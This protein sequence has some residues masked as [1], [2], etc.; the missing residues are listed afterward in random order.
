M[1]KFYQ[2]RQGIGEEAVEIFRKLP[3]KRKWELCEIEHIRWCRYHFMNNWDY[4]PERNNSQRR[5]NLLVPFDKLDKKNQEKDM[6]A[7]LVLE[8]I[9]K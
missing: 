4:A 1:Q 9:M 8:E 5:H 7:Y 2:Q 6:D 3:E